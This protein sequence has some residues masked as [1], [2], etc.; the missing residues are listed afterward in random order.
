MNTL[1]EQ[2]CRKELPLKEISKQYAYLVY[3]QEV[4]SAPIGKPLFGGFS[5]LPVVWMGGKILPIERGTK[6]YWTQTD[7]DFLSGFSV[8]HSKEWRGR[9]DSNPRPLP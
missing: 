1:W 8:N 5:L 4:D 7:P 6:S 2:Y 3:C 9:R